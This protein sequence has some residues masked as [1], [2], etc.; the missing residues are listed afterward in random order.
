MIYYCADTILPKM[1]VGWGR[2]YLLGESCTRLLYCNLHGSDKRQLLLQK[3]VLH[4]Q[5]SSCS[6]SAWGRMKMPPSRILTWWPFKYM[7]TPEPFQS[8]LGLP[9]SGQSSILIS[10]EIRPDI[11]S[12]VFLPRW[13]PNCSTWVPLAA[14]I[15]C[16]HNGIPL[17][18]EVHFPCS[19]GL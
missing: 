14:F 13:K 17:L 10:L 7:K 6:N 8:V 9:S 1:S 18:G 4:L 15:V 11:P 16:W 5:N 3:A 2:D 19:H 12:V